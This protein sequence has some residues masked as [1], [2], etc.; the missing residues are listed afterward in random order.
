[1]EVSGALF[2]EELRVL[3]E[4][5]SGYGRLDRLLDTIVIWLFSLIASSK[6]RGLGLK[7]VANLCFECKGDTCT[8]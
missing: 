5:C 2:L 4:K 7:P 3:C 1:M 8:P 6:D